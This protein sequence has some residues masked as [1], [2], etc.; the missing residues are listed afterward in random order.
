MKRIALWTIAA[1]AVVLVTGPVSGQAYTITIP[2]ADM[3]AY[4]A[5][6]F[7]QGLDSGDYFQH[8]ADGHLTVWQYKDAVGSAGI[9]YPPSGVY[10][11][12]DPGSNN[13]IGYSWGG[14]IYQV[15]LG[16]PLLADTAYTLSV[17]AGQR[18]G[19]SNFAEGSTLELWVV[20]GTEPLNSVELAVPLAGTFVQTILGVPV[21]TDAS[22]FGRDLEIRLVCVGTGT[23]TK[24]VD[25]DLFELTAIYIPVPEPAT[26]T[27]LALGGLAMLRRRRK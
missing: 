12:G 27:L 3:G 16:T 23:G 19:S 24:V 10:P 9:Y 4:T 25:F 5:T 26:M 15:L 17:W 1:V 8:G 7:P 22:L 14:T 11:D 18:A 6:Y 20:G 21:I 13:L 2:D